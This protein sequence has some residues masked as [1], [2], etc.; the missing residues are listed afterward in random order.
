[1]CIRD[2]VNGDIGDFITTAVENFGA[3]PLKDICN[4][5][6]TGAFPVSDSLSDSSSN[7]GFTGD[8]ISGGII[9]YNT[10][11]VDDGNLASRIA[12]DD[13]EYGPCASKGEP[14]LD[15]GVYIFAWPEG[16][17]YGYWTWSDIK[18]E[19]PSGI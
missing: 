14:A 5:L 11:E 9:S 3:N 4:A 13:E 10:D 7:D 8:I 2:S 16:Q 15:L 19:M 12:E 17:W 1:M 6:E 18:W